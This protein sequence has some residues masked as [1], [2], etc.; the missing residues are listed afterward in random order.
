ML[1]KKFT[2]KR[3]VC[4]VTFSIPSEIV[5]KEVALVGDFND[6]N[7][8]QGTIMKSSKAEYKAIIELP[9]GKEYAFRYWIDQQKWEN[10]WAADA[11]V[12]SPF[13]GVDNSIVIIDDVEVAAPAAKKT[14]APTKKAAAPAKKKVAKT[15]K[16]KV[17]KPTKDSL[18]KIEGIGPKIEKLLNARDITTFKGLAKAK[19]SLL[20]EILQ[21]AGSRY[22]MHDPTTW[23]EQAALAAKGQWDEL[24]TL[25]DELK[26]GKRK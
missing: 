18:K 19:Q 13:V 10:D 21:E 11:Y 20:Q 1:N 17:A 9:V 2:P 22:K 15:A 7:W 26:G 8:D 3:T 6:W 23:P 25:Q 14:T 24:K 16:K 12:P 5:A 4:K